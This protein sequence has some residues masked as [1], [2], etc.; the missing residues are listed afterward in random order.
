MIKVGI[1]GTG[2]RGTSFV[3]AIEKIPEM[4]VVAIVDSNPIRMEAVIKHHNYPPVEKFTSIDELLKTKI[5]DIVFITTPDWTHADLIIKCLESGYHVFCDKPLAIDEKQIIKILEYSKNSNKMK[6]MGFNMRY[7]TL[8]RKIKEIVDNGDIGKIFVGWGYSGYEG[9]GYFR[10]WHKF[11]EKSGGL[12]VH[13]GCHI[14][15]ILNW[16]VNSYPVEVYAIGGLSVFGGNKKWEGC[17]KCEETETC[18][19][20]RRLDEKNEKLLEDIY[21]KAAV[22]DGYTRNY[23]VFGPT[24]VYDHYLVEISYA[25]GVK[26]S[27]NEIFFGTG[28][29][30]IGFAGEKG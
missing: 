10:R 23:C 28:P 4:K 18:P 20:V 14:I 7:K 6:F 12:I 9:N 8:F 15:D 13:K 3:K 25:N 17:H 30:F 24:N 27:F 11:R 16:I 5:V 29:F 19:Y 1:V 21:I 26:V 22:V 2:D